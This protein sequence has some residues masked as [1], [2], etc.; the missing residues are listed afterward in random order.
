[1]TISKKQDIEEQ[2][3]QWAVGLMSGDNRAHTEAD[4]ADWRDEDPRHSQAY[5]ELAAMTAD[6]DAV[7]EAALQEEFERE[8]HEAAEERK[9]QRWVAGISSLAAGF[10]VAAVLSVSMWVSAPEPVTYATAKGQRSTIALADGS[11]LQ[12]NTNTQVT[13][14]MEDDERHVTI[15]RG[16]AFFSV[17]RDESRP[18]IVDAGDTQ[19][20]V[21]GTK[22]NVRLGASSNV[23]S[24]LSGLVSVAQRS[25][26]D[27][28]REVALLHA[29]EQAE[30]DAN[31]NEAVVEG[32]DT[33]SVMAW[34][35]GKALYHETP[36]SVV[37]QDLNRYFNAP[38][39][40]A[41]AQLADLP[42]SGTF[43]LTDQDVVVDALESAFSI[44][45]VKRLDGVILLYARQKN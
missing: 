2:A 9:R 24:V 6:L 23:V 32:F 12:L 1:M 27:D 10:V 34:R 20:R 45:A 28:V 42:V 29:G 43:N 8:L 19:V 17:K 33:G 44:D 39:E 21:L 4:L 25:D 14:L 38:L 37:V 18:F 13:T 36:L 26:D 16:E 5:A 7:G 30:H 15:E 40:I 31:K 22:F 3:A 41:D 35:T 11:V